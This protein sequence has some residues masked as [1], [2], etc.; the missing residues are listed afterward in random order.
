[1][2]QGRDLGLVVLTEGDPQLRNDYSVILVNPQRH[3]HVRQEAAR[4]FAEFLLAPAARS[5]IAKFGVDKFGQPLFFVA[6]QP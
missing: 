6:I 3:P 5:L 4:R 2:A 1:L